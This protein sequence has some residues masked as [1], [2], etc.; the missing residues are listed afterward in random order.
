[1]E[2]LSRYTSRIE[3]A[4]RSLQLVG[5][6]YFVFILGAQATPVCQTDGSLN[7]GQWLCGQIFPHV[8]SYKQQFGVRV[9]E[10]VVDI[11]RLEVL[12]DRYDN[13]LV[14]HDS[15]IG[16]RP[17]GAVASAQS[18]LVALLDT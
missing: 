2:V 7:A 9:R 14:G 6:R 11:F 16:N 13:S 18:D 17:I 10:Q 3:F 5:V 4:E 1:M 12:Q 15:Q 8:R